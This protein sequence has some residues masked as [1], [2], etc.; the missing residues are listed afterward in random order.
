MYYIQYILQYLMVSMRLLLGHSPLLQPLQMRTG[1][2]GGRF[3]LLEMRS[4]SK[5]EE[6]TLEGAQSSQKTPAH[7][8][9]WCFRVVNFTSQ[10]L[11]YSIGSGI[12]QREVNVRLSSLV[13]PSLRIFSFTLEASVKVCEV[14]FCTPCVTLFSIDAIA[15]TSCQYKPTPGHRAR[16]DQG[17]IHDRETS[18]GFWLSFALRSESS[19]ALTCHTTG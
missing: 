11:Q 2:P 17:S 7:D 12:S 3:R 13:W 19:W 5:V 15:K 8:R 9:Q 6:G 16:G 14:S 10:P 1:A 18:F 4:S